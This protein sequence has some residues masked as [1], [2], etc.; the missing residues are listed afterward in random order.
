M[1]NSSTN[2]NKVINHL[3]PQTIEHKKRPYMALKWEQKYGGVCVLVHHWAN[4]LC[5]I[6]VTFTLNCVHWSVRR[7]HIH[8]YEFQM[9]QFY[10]CLLRHVVYYAIS[11]FY[12]V[13]L[14]H[15]SVPACFFFLLTESTSKIG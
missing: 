6:T 13:Q 3:S 10:G 9:Q 1:V 2:S 4:S 7:I 14:Q 5:G 8:V 15:T 11:K 12:I